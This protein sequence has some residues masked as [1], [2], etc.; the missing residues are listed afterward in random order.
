MIAT[1]HFVFLHLHKSGGTFVNDC[2]LSCLN[3]ALLLG[4]HL[5]RRMIPPPCAHL[6]V[7]GL[8]RSPW[9]YYVSWYAFQSARPR[10][11]VLFTSLSEDGRLGFGATIRNMLELGIRD[12][13]L[14]ALLARLP[15]AYGDRGLNLP[16]S[17][18][19]PIR[20]SG[21]GFFTY[22]YRYLFDGPGEPA[23]IARMESLREDLPA[24]VAATGHPGSTVMRQ[25]ILERAPLNASRH[26]ACAHYY[27]ARLRELVARRDAELIDRYG[28][29]CDA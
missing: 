23:R 6:P 22:L 21:L 13:L 17:A 18:L 26:E 9:S 14:D 8:V 1:S 3:D 29:R 20:G 25:A 12:D 10:P 7:L 16:R 4:Y 24:L 2:L 28:Y 27:D 5:P 19:E 11:N 15:A